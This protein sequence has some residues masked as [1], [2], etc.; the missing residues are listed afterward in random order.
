[1]QRPASTAFTAVGIA[2]VVA[3]FIGMLALANGFRAALARTGSDNN[4]LVLR[5]GADSELS[6]G[7]DRETANLLASSL[8]VALAADGRPLV[9]PEVYVL[10][11]LVRV[12]GDS[13]AVGNVVV[14]GISEKVDAHE[15]RFKGHRPT[16]APRSASEAGRRPVPAYDS[17]RQLR[18]SRLE[19][20]L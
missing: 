4:A 11:P 20:G 15:H 19:R 7:I 12:G 13:N 17:R 2:L 9:S 16:S 14:R 10:V 18:G 8:H 6:S 1:L 5:R 3:V